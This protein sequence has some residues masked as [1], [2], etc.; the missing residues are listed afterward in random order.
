MLW[1]RWTCCVGE[2]Q[3]KIKSHEQLTDILCLYFSHISLQQQ[4]QTIYWIRWILWNHHLT[5]FVHHSLWANS[6]N[7]VNWM[8]PT[9]AQS[10][11]ESARQMASLKKSTEWMIYFKFCNQN[12][13]KVKFQIII[14]IVYDPRRH[15]QR[16]L[17]FLICD[18]N[19]NENAF[20][21]NLLSNRTLSNKHSILPQALYSR[22]EMFV[23]RLSQFFFMK[24]ICDNGGYGS[25]AFV[26]MNFMGICVVMNGGLYRFEKQ[27]HYYSFFRRD[28]WSSCSHSWNEY[29]FVEYSEIN[30]SPKYQKK[31]KLR[32]YFRRKTKFLQ[33]H[34][35]WLSCYLRFCVVVEWD[36]K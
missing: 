10:A 23:M 6:T 36:W 8:P 1:T 35:N 19:N 25:L 5:T 30:T 17:C 18:K 7:K 29:I 15:L 34:K 31:N 3:N 26:Y 27:L 13:G 2:H 22:T 14:L 24:I 16:I 9:K 28:N 32:P 11:N 20:D 33:E 4:T 21:F 12:K